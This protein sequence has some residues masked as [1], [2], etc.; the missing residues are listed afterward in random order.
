MSEVEHE[1]CARREAVKGTEGEKQKIV[2]R[3]IKRA[4]G[5]AFL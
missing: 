2:R 5:R 4:R 1:R 3:T